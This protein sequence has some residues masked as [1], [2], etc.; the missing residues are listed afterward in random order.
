ME[1][2]ERESEK[3]M[4]MKKKKDQ[5]GNM[6]G[7]YKGQPKVVLGSLPP[8]L[9]EQCKS[10]SSFFAPFTIYFLFSYKRFSRMGSVGNQA[11]VGSCYQPSV[12][13]SSLLNK[14]AP[15][16]WTGERIGAAYRSA[17]LLL[18][19]LKPAGW[20]NPLCLAESAVVSWSLLL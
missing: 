17:E 9:K 11:P 14:T 19:A 10:W 15:K 20:L 5:E 8:R 18:T 16:L 13:C 7:K 12:F 2:G 6:P 4:W 1:N 3:K